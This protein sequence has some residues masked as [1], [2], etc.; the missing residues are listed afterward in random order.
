[1]H[2]HIDLVVRVGDRLAA[3]IFVGIARGTEIGDHYDDGV[4]E[5]TLVF[6]RVRV[7]SRGYLEATPARV[8]VRAAGTERELVGGGG[9]PG[10][11]PIAARGI[12]AARVHGEGRVALGIL[13]PAAIIDQVRVSLGRGVASAC[14]CACACACA[15]GGARAGGGAVGTTMMLVLVRHR[16]PCNSETGEEDEDKSER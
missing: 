15:G 8:A 5:W 7:R 11:H 1:V 16:M 14:A 12:L 13:H 9:V 10:V 2:R 3:P 6:R 4:P